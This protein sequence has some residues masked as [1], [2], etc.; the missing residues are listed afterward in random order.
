M[1]LKTTITTGTRMHNNLEEAFKKCQNDAV[2]A[3]TFY[4]SYYLG[5]WPVPTGEPNRLIDLNLSISKVIFNDPATIILW[6]DGSKT[7][8]KCCEDDTFDYEKGM[9][10]AICK[11]IMGYRFKEIFKEWLPEEE[12]DN[13]SQP[14]SHDEVIEAFSKSLNNLNNLSFSFKLDTKE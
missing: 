3:M 2:D 6:R 13:T 10:M 9:A 7:V 1:D 4:T 8:V 14:L 5:K 12:E 11:K